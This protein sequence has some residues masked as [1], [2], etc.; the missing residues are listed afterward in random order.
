MWGRGTPSRCVPPAVGGWWSMAGP[1]P[2]GV[3]PGANN[4]QWPRQRVG[5]NNVDD[6]ECTA[7][8]TWADAGLEALA[9]NGGPTL[10]M[11]PG[12]GS[13]VGGAG[14]DCPATDQRGQPRPAQGCAAGAVE[15]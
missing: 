2:P 1:E 12:A 3:M 7:G 10:T 13:V 11:M 4:F 8:I 5:T 14:T 15:P 6:N 9:D